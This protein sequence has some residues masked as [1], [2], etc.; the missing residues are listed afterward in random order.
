M[1]EHPSVRRVLYEEVIDPAVLVA[2]LGATDRDIDVPCRI[3][4][5][6]ELRDDRTW[7]AEG[8]DGR[9]ELAEQPPRG[10]P[11]LDD[12][13]GRAGRR[14][15]G[16]RAAALGCNGDDHRASSS[17]GHRERSS[18][19]SGVRDGQPAMRRCA[20][21]YTQMAWWNESAA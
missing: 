7:C 1:S 11:P 3:D 10:R 21:E 9:A 17:D 8:C 19:R 20:G 6:R 12:I 4:G 16:N 13:G 18:R 5:N 14:P 15:V 2:R